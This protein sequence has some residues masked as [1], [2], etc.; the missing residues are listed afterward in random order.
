MHQ[1]RKTTTD[2]FIWSR[3]LYETQKNLMSINSK[4]KYAM[5]IIP[6]LRLGRRKETLVWAIFEQQS[7]LFWHCSDSSGKGWS[8]NNPTI[9]VWACVY[10]WCVFTPTNRLIVSLAGSS[11]QWLKSQAS[12]LF[13]I[14]WLQ[15]VCVRLIIYY[16]RLILYED[17]SRTR[18]ECA[19]SC[20]KIL[21]SSWIMICTYVCRL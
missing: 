5:L 4:L 21:Q 11:D 1:W 20:V 7:C 10:L 19:T 14:C 6:L 12:F 16:T 8:Q 13:I 3:T 2:T 15:C 17:K 18:P 9:C